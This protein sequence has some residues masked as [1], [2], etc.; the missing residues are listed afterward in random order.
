[1]QDEKCRRSGITRRVSGG[2]AGDSRES[3][4]YR[5]RVEGRAP[6]HARRARCLDARVVRP[7]SPVL[8]AKS[9]ALLC[10][11]GNAGSESW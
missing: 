3:R 8:H 9:P 4:R 11:R 1:M 7:R 5:Q 10:R 2:A 6:V